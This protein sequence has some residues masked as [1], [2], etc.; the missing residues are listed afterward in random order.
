MTQ[1]DLNI[2]C[3]GL[4][5]LLDK[6][7]V[8]DY[9]DTNIIVKYDDKKIK[10][11]F[12][13]LFS[14]ITQDQ[15]LLKCNKLIITI[16]EN[17]F[18]TQI[19]NNIKSDLLIHF[20]EHSQEYYTLFEKYGL[21]TLL[22][23]N[24]C[25]ELDH[26]DLDITL[27]K[28]SLKDKTIRIKYHTEHHSKM[29]F[30]STSYCHKFN[31]IKRA[32]DK[33]DK[34][35]RDAT[36]YKLR[37]NSIECL[38][39]CFKLS[40]N[41]I[42]CFEILGL[43]IM[44]SNGNYICKSFTISQQPQYH[45]SKKLITK[46]YFTSMNE[47]INHLTKLIFLANKVI[48]YP[49]SIL[50]TCSKNMLELRNSIELT[51]SIIKRDQ[52]KQ[53]EKREKELYKQRLCICLIEMKKVINDKIH[54]EKLSK[55]LIEMA[56]KYVAPKVYD[57]ECASY[58]SVETQIIDSDIKNFK[59]TSEYKSLKEEYSCNPYSHHTIYGEMLQSRTYTPNF[60]K[61]VCSRECSKDSS[62]IQFIDPLSKDDAMAKE[63]LIS[64]LKAQNGRRF[65]DLF[66]HV[67]KVI[68][69]VYCEKYDD[70]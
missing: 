68:Q 6:K 3:N 4:E 31:D 49:E 18:Y 33:I 43:C 70:K 56:S 34:R 37:M 41:C 53:K 50:N 67:Y 48:N 28:F 42:G 66:D 59:D 30:N 2:V 57:L 25:I 19:K 16:N 11:I 8:Y 5:V 7:L 29:C 21:Y 22:F 63:I 40:K 13:Y 58:G 51:T 47:L 62:L 60:I 55:C 23:K 26:R 32:I 24:N 52:K 69:N 27:F 17:D 20:I 35:V 15:I 14:K 9:D 12:R 36:I 1:I 46:Q 39:N 65:C 61:Q 10:I 38:P 45:D 64:S 44:L 54:K